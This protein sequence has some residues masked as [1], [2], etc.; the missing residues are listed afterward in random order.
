MGL[1]MA[2]LGTI[3]GA[4]NFITTILCMRAPGLTVWRMPIFTWNALITSL[5][6]IM[7]FPP[8]AA[9]LFALGMDRTLGG[10]IFDPVAL[11]R[12]RVGGRHHARRGQPRGRR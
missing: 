7:V 4:V 3:L 6:V 10:H 8:L 12:T 5:M 9:A 2:G 1:W 11:V